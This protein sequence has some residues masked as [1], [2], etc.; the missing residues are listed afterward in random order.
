MILGLSS[1]VAN[2]TCASYQLSFNTQDTLILK[3]ID[4][5]RLLTVNRIIIIGNKRTRDPIILRELTLKVGDTIRVSKLTETLQR[6]KRK[7]YN[8][9]LFNVVN[10]RSIE[11]SLGNIDLLIELEERWYTWPT[12]IFELSDRNFNEWWQNYNHD[13]S[14]VNFGMRL[15][16]FNVRGRNETLRFKAQFGFT[17]QFNLSYTIPYIDKK[18]KQ[19]LII[20]FDYGNPKNIDYFTDDH[21]LL[22]LNSKE[23]LRVYRSGGISYTYRKSF[24]ETH[25]LSL[26]F[27][28]SEISDTINT[29]NPNYYGSPTNQQQFGTIAYAFN[30]EHRDVVLYPL[31]GYQFTAYLE[32]SGFGFEGSVNQ[33]IMNLTYATHK[34]LRKGFY[35]SNFTSLYWSDPSVQPYSLY[36]AMGYQKQ[37]VRGYEIYLIEG[38]KFVVNKTTFKKKIFAHTWRWENVPLEQFRHLPFAVYL[39]SFIDLGYVENYPAYTEQKINTRLSDTLLA[40]FGTGLD[41]TMPY[42]GVLRMEYTFT[43]DGTQGFFFNLK[44]EF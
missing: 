31:K 42:D 36:S 1:I 35:L 38:P 4:S 24:F 43:R 22:F 13:L 7:L 9:R 34:D 39:K 30:S 28:K 18:Q 6:D 10:I 25:L 11:M 19:G 14:R 33:W 12:P 16:Q 27:Q 3:S 26:G 17:Q 40:G 41:I 20:S 5:I 32:K 21:K 44:K 29:L 8:L 37:I 15:E 23:P 2:S